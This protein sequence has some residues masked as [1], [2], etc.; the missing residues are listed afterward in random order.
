MNFWDISEKFLKYLSVVKGAS[1]HTIRAYATD[2]ATFLKFIGDVPVSKR[3]VRRFLSHLYENQKSTKTVLRM[4]SS[5]RSLY[6]YALVE[7]LVQENPLGEIESPK[8]EKKLP[9]SISYAQVEHLLAQPN[10]QDYLGFRDRVI[11]ELFYS[12]GLRLSEL[13]GLSRGDFDEKS[14]VLTI[15]G[16]G[17]KQRQTPITETAT[18]LLI[19]YLNHPERGGVEKDPEAIFLNKWGTRLSSRSVDRNFATYL[20]LS[21]LSEK[22]TPHTIRHTIATHWLEQGMDLKTIQLLLGH[23]SLATTTIYTHVS[24]KLKKEVYDKTHPRA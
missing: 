2:F 10:T 8:K 17:K 24:P 23:S 5:L 4:L 11:M 6:K 9:I 20:K 14:G 13:T 16:K 1:P 12:S 3:E 18:K 15:F 19:S 21:G 22:I 7:K